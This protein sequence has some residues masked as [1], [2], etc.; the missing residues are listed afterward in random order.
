MIEMAMKATRKWKNRAPVPVPGISLLRLFTPALVIAFLFFWQPTVVAVG[1][2]AP[3]VIS[4]FSPPGGA[5]GTSVTILGS[6][7][8]AVREVRFNSAVAIFT[9]VSASQ[10]IA[11][12]PLDAT[13]GPIR[14]STPTDTAGTL[15]SFFVS[16]RIDDFSPTNGSPGAS[17][18]ITGANFAGATA[19]RFNDKNAA[20]F[21]VVAETQIQAV[22][23]A[24]G[25]SGPIS[26]TTPV[27]TISS[28][29]NFV[30]TGTEPFLNDFSPTNGAP[31]TIVTIEGRNFA[32]ATAVRFNGMNAAQFFVTAPTQIRATVPSGATTGTIGVTTPSGTGAS[33]RPFVVT[34]SPVISA[35][36]PTN[37]PPGT[38]VVIDGS[39]FAGATAV[40]FNGTTA[41]AF[42]ITA[43][44]Q[45]RA[46]V[47]MGATAG[48]VSVT[49]PSGTGA[50]ANPFVVSTIPIIT[51]FS[52]T[53]GPVGT[54]VVIDGINFAGVTAV[55][56]NGT[57]TPNFSVTSPTQISA[58]VPPGATT[59]LIAVMAPPGTGTS[60]NHFR[61]TT[62]IP[63]IFSFT[64]ETGLPGT[65]VKIEG[66]DFTG[67]TAV[68]FNG[69]NASFTV[70]A[71]T[72]I[73]CTVPA[74]A[75]SGLISVTTP[76]GTGFSSTRFIVAPRLTSFS[77]LNGAVGSSVIV[78]GTN[79]TDVLAVKFGGAP[80][81]FTNSSPNEITAIVPAGA[82]SG[83]ITVT[84]PAGIVAS[85]N[86]FVVTFS[87]DLPVSLSI[88]FVSANRAVISWPG[89]ATNFVL[90][91]SEQLTLPIA[92]ALVT[93]TPVVTGDR[94][95][96]TLA[97]DRN[98][99]YRLSKP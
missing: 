9:A 80:A 35:F 53:N 41:S 60:T 90:Q 16:P 40:R 34:A 6:N 39:N 50:S 52:P 68:K 75:T 77:P 98:R 86:D 95:T 2:S 97:L 13:S 64:P 36:S 44:T 96:V 11:T 26:V 99:F 88:Q 17:V 63:L 73:N 42:S 49:T 83:P 79:F 47:P 82:L 65:M 29:N 3:P 23:P 46:T 85:T 45:I 22:V 71:P 93:N 67:A 84:T 87:A 58:T 15:D 59:G 5:P 1:K 62:G 33:A 38:S 48:P 94:K 74:E 31:G 78:R 25:S 55:R 14:V 7:F 76:L 89:A 51:G 92:W 20:S 32:G 37:G 18:T 21:A 66:Q 8:S 43:S 27:G 72:Q 54:I 12:V 4:S 19:V 70:T 56:F 61:V 24:G 91:T 57:N 10:L 30:I 69:T 28:T 81:T